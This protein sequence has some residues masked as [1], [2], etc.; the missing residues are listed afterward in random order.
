MLYNVFIVSNLIGDE[1]DKTIEA[2]IKVNT[3]ITANILDTWYHMLYT[4][5]LDYKKCVYTCT[6]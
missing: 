6:K 2:Y 4:V 5:F 3:S 1:G